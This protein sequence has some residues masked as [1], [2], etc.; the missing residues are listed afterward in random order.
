MSLSYT[1][2]ERLNG[3][4]VE[5]T[6]PENRKQAWEVYREVMALADKD[7]AAFKGAVRLWTASD[8][9]ICGLFHSWSWM[10]DP[11]YDRPEVDCDFQ[12]EHARWVQF[13]GDGSLNYSARKHWKSTWNRVRM[14]QEIVR[15]PDV[16][17]AI[18]SADL[19]LAQKHLNSWKTEVE[20]NDIMKMS[21]DDVFYQNPRDDG[22]FWSLEKGCTVKR[23][24]SS[25]SPTV[26]A[27]TFLAGLPDGSRFGIIVY[28]DIETDKSIEAEEQRDKVKRR[29]RKSLQLGGIG[30]RKWFEGTFKH[31]AGLLRGLIED[32]WPAVC[33]TAEDLEH[34]PP[35][36]AVLYDECGGRT[37][38]GSKIPEPVREIRLRG[39]PRYLHPL[40]CAMDRWEQTD[41]VYEMES[42]GDPLAGQGL[43]FRPE[44]VA[45][46]LRV[47]ADLHE[48]ARGKLGYILSDPS[49]GLRDPSVG[50]VLVTDSDKTI[51]LVGGFR[52]KA[53]PSEWE[54]LMYG[55]VSE[56]QHD[57]DIRQIRIEVYGQATWDHNLRSYFE[58]RNFN[59]PPVFGVGTHYG[60]RRPMDLDQGL[61]R[62][63]SRLEPL[64]RTGKLRLPTRLMVTD[65][66]D[67]PYCLVEYFIDHEYSLFP[68]PPTDDIFAAL[69]L[70]G[71]PEYKVP[72][73]EYPDREVPWGRDDEEFGMVEP[74]IPGL[75]EES[76]LWN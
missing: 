33:F 37:P 32:R 17:I 25:I 6:L 8:L 70:L 18:F 58:A 64:F 4:T 21:W 22:A 72:G 47:K 34:P 29:F 31:P 23:T 46:S 15:D 19:K 10:T 51:T 42:M 68:K 49:K 11:W 50:L 36:I 1:Y 13:E 54:S 27:Y 74:P 30:C 69:S 62:A 3:E 26:S 56:W 20:T 24:R 55:L 45:E 71:E 73:L 67:T 59:G 35:D 65:E 75:D 16:C 44:W 60:N 43:R 40:Q 61:F 7:P 9:Y 63:W 28:T 57:I 14:S 39:K 12:F 48:F 38:K 41:E 76:F 52:K 5:V 2:T 66:K 53:S